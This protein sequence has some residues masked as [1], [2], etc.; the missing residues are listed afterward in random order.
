MTIDRDSTADVMPGAESPYRDAPPEP[1]TGEAS[2]GS[3]AMWRMAVDHAPIGIAL[4]SLDGR[5]TSANPAWC[6]VLGYP[7]HVLLGMSF[8]EITHPEDL[9]QDRELFRRCQRGEIDRYDVEKRYVTA[10]GSIVWAH[11]SANLARSASGE[12]MHFVSLI[13]DITHAKESQEKLAHQALH[14]TLTGL[15]NRALLMDRL[16]QALARA[17]RRRAVAVLYCDIDRFK[18]VNEILGHAAGDAM[19]MEVAQR[20][21]STIRSTDTVARLAGD[22]FAVVCDD[23]SS[24]L[25]ATR[26]A[27]ALIDALAEPFVIDGR[28]ATVSMSLGV[29]VVPGG[30]AAEDALREA[31][32]AKSLA[33][34]RGRSRWELFDPDLRGQSAVDRIAVETE[35]RVALVEDQLV[36]HYQPI[37]ALAT[38]TVVG[39]EALVRWMHPTRGLLAPADFLPVAEES[40]LINALGTV[41]LDRAASDVAT[42]D[43]V[44]GA[45]LWVA[46]NVSGQQLGR[47]ELI[48]AVERALATSGL[49]AERLHLEVTETALFSGAEAAFDDLRRLQDLGTGLSLDDFGTGYSSLTMLRD[50]PVSTLKL[51][52]SFVARLGQDAGSTA[53]VEAVI[54]LGRVL[55]LDVVAEGI[56]TAAQAEL[57]RSFGCPLGQGYYF[58]RPAP[59]P[60]PYTG[61]PVA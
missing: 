53:I 3:A 9:E 55:E 41:V 17:R 27:Q 59:R 49:C 37:V 28:E 21:R 61:T 31:D 23:V 18:S 51:D 57:L 20:L 43:L 36:V 52:R 25:E 22:E 32:A 1:A 34:E 40:A 8:E 58:G 6:A 16:E 30:M 5:M 48:P 38:S 10:A 56:E 13:H 26:I 42:W 24:S 2:L 14:D 11:L 45:P 47:G 33:K 60:A 39:Y 15:P 35:L 12:P 44:D 19:L 50:A 7:E 46:V 54:A 29:T 4:V